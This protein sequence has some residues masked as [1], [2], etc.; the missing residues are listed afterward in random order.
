M[1]IFSLVM[2]LAEHWWIIAILALLTCA[3]AV[4][5]GAVSLAAIIARVLQAIAAIIA[6]FVT[7]AN[8]IASK[9]LYGLAL[10]CIGAWLGHWGGV[11]ST[12]AEWKAADEAV[13]GKADRTDKIITKNAATTDQKDVAADDA[14]TKSTDEDRNAY[15][16]SLEKQLKDSCTANPAIL[17]RLRNIR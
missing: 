15:V 9:I 8:Q 17:R 13:Q 14:A 4:L 12:K 16:T 3:G 6:F 2:W 1:N 10:F 11:H 7:P 5:S